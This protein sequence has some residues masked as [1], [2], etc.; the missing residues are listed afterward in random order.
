MDIDYPLRQA[1]PSMPKASQN[2]AKDPVEVRA[3]G[4]GAL[5]SSVF[6]LNSHLKI[7]HCWCLGIY[8]KAVLS[9][10]QGGSNRTNDLMA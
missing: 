8:L 2:D 9:P 10:F 6:K 1:S 7:M 5:E 4:C 3:I